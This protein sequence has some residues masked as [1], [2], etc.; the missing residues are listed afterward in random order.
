MGL[1]IG[2]N[3][4][5]EKFSSARESRENAAPG[6]QPR[7]EKSRKPVRGIS[8]PGFVPVFADFSI[9]NANSALTF[10]ILSARIDKPH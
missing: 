7:E 2:K 6:R 10:H 8:F 1:S 3:G 5:F 9:K 4:F